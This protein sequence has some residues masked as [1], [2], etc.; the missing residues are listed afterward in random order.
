MKKSLIIL[1]FLTVISL[2]EAKPRMTPSLSIWGVLLEYKTNDGISYFKIQM[3]FING[4]KSDEII[5]IQ[6]TP[7]SDELAINENYNFYFYYPKF[8]KDYWDLKIISGGFDEYKKLNKSWHSND[9]YFE[10]SINKRLKIG[11]NK[12]F[13]I[14]HNKGNYSLK[15]KINDLKL[16]NSEAFMR[17]D[18][19]IDEEYTQRLKHAEVE[20]YEIN[21]DKDEFTIPPYFI[22]ICE[23]NIFIDEQYKIEKEYY[24]YKDRSH[25]EIDTLH[26]ASESLVIWGNIEYKDELGNTHKLID[27]VYLN[28]GIIL[29]QIIICSD[30]NDNCKNSIFVY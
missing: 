17:R 19:R 6:S 1:L 24:L 3:K 20:N 23:L 22:N 28:D 5:E 2:I 4:K 16:L 11:W 9:I 25:K 7:I 10:S 8:D 26:T 12:L 18:S 29:T 27:S 15:M 30:K 14:V 21:T 13:C